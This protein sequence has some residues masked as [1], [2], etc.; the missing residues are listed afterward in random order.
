VVA[1]S[2]GGP[3][4]IADAP[5]VE[6]RSASGAIRLNNVA[7]RLRAVT[8]RGS[9]VAEILSGHPLSDSWLSTR[10]GDITV[11][12]PSDI[13]VTIEAE[14]GGTHNVESIVSDYS[15][16]RIRSTPANATAEGRI[17]G[18]GPLLRLID[19]GGRIEIK[20]K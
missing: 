14:T 6:C 11:F 15:G 4:E 12:I 2:A 8:G 1:K 16:L 3:I 7:G 10:A 18:G 13:G 9:I 17:N 20:K 5:S 19:V